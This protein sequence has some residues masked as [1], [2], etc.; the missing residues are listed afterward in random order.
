MNIFLIGK[1]LSLLI[2][3]SRDNLCLGIP[4]HAWTN[5]NFLRKG[6]KNGSIVGTVS[7]GG[8]IQKWCLLLGKWKWKAGNTFNPA[9]LRKYNL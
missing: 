5:S 9:K 8:F 1:Y 2:L 3:S 6:E 4:I 7:T